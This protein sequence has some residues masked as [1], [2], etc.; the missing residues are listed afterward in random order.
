MPDPVPLATLSDAVGDDDDDENEGEFY[1]FSCLLP[2]PPAGAVSGAAGYGVKKGLDAATRKKRVGKISW[3]QW[4]ANQRV[5]ANMRRRWHRV[6]K[7]TS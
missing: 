5:L 1:P 3:A 6:A 7:A 2:S 4:R